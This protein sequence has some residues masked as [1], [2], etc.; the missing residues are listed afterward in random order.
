MAPSACLPEHNFSIIQLAF[1]SPGAQL[2]NLD[3]IVVGSDVLQ[4]MG[5][6][7][8]KQ[9]Q[10]MLLGQLLYLL[11]CQA[12]AIVQRVLQLD[13]MYALVYMLAKVLCIRM[14]GMSDKPENQIVR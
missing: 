6:A 9:D 13:A 3:L 5:I 7:I 14:A 12:I 1:S 11:L 10:V 4:P 2:L 8:R